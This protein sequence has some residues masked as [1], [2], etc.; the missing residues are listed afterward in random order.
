MPQITVINTIPHHLQ[1]Y[2]TCGDWQFDAAPGLK[3]LQIKVSDTGDEKMNF[4]LALHEYIEAMLCHFAGVTDTQVDEYDMAHPDT[5]GNSNLDDNTTA[6]YYKQHCTAL[7]IEWL[8]AQQ[9]GVSWP[10]YGE[11]IASLCFDQEERS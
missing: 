8:I 9:I 1:R 5:A 6:P 7:A 2:D 3:S 11:K 4:L 10:E